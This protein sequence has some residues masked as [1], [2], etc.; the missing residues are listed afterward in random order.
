MRIL[1]LQEKSMNV[2]EAINRGINLLGVAVL[3]IDSSLA[4]FEIFNE[5]E[6]IDR[7]DDLV[8]LILAVIGIV[9]YLAGSNRYRRSPLPWVLL[10]LAWVMKVIGLFV[11]EHDDANAAGPDYGLIVTLLLGAIIVAW[12]YFRARRLS[13]VEAQ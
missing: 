11:I 4:L 3:G 7:L 6:W 9:W 5:T 1:H 13:T 12:Q 8:V 10:S 2:R